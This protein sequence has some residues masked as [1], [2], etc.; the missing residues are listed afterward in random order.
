M[1]PARQPIELVISQS[2]KKKG[3]VR[4]GIYLG[5]LQT[6]AETGESGR[7][8]KLY[9]FNKSAGKRHEILIREYGHRKS[10]KG[11]LRGVCVYVVLWKRGL[12][13]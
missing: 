4:R 1:I 9:I 11:R 3:R 2:G 10:L 6:E 8:N 12:F 13:M 5:C 7:R